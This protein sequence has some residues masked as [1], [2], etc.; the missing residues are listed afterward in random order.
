MRR[1]SHTPASTFIMAGML[2]AAVVALALVVWLDAHA[3]IAVLAGLNVATVALYGYDK[4]CAGRE[5][6]RVPEWALHC[7]AFAGGSPGALLAQQ[8]FR[9][10]T[11]KRSFRIV[12]W[13]LVAAQAGLIGYVLW[14]QR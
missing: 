7:F 8:L 5:R 12:F 9:H 2:L 11:R 1:K 13:L 6:S 14:Q 3:V 4:W 10:K